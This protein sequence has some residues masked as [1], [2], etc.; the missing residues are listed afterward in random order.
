MTVHN[1]N[2]IKCDIEGYEYELFKNFDIPEYVDEIWMETH[3]FDIGTKAEHEYLKKRL[4]EY[5]FV[6][7]E[8]R[9]DEYNR[10]YL[11]HAKR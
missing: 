8:I 4:F 9:N 11:L 10:T 1:P 5:G 2:K 6:V 7:N 3:T